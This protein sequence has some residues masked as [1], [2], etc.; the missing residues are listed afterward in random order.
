[1]KLKKKLNTMNR[2]LLFSA[3]GTL[4]AAQFCFGAEVNPQGYKIP[5]VSNAKKGTVQYYDLTDKIEGEETRIDNYYVKHPSGAFNG[6]V[7][8]IKVSIR[9]RVFMYGVEGL[10]DYYAI[11]DNDGNGIFETKYS[12]EEIL[13]KQNEG[14]LIP[15]WVL[16][17]DKT[18]EIKGQIVLMESSTRVNNPFGEKYL[19]RLTLR[20]QDGTYAHC[21]LPK[22]YESQAK[23]LYEEFHMDIF[24]KPRDLETAVVSEI[25]DSNVSDTRAPSTYKEWKQGKH[26]LIKEFQ[27]NGKTFKFE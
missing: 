1:M 11:F 13:K 4:V 26:Y 8:V 22:S 15:E 18:V 19:D 24:E 12:E 6:L 14:S 20:L 3:L 27:I 23:R 2:S 16:H 25:N 21:W 10:G 9:D 7:N 17:D 5:D